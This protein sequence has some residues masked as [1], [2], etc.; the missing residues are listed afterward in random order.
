MRRPKQLPEQILAR[1]T[2]ILGVGISAGD[3]TSIVDPTPT[4]GTDGGVEAPVLTPSPSDFI[5]PSTPTLSGTVQGIRVS[6]DGKNANGNPYPAGAFVE[7]H[8]STSGATFTPSS[9]TLAGRLLGSAG[10]FTIGALTAGTTYY[11]RLVGVDEAGNTTS[12]STAASGQTGLTTENDYGTGTV[13]VGAVSFNARQ[14]GGIATTVGS[15]A[16][17]SPVT[18]DIWLDSSSGTSIIHK[19]WNGSSWVTQAWGSDSLSANCITSVQLATGAIVAGSAVI[20]DA[21]IRNAQIASI[22]ADK[23]TAGVIS[24]DRIDTNTLTGKTLRTAASGKRVE[25]SSSG[26][27]NG[28]IEFYNSSSVR[29]GYI[30]GGSSYVEIGAPDGAIIRG[31]MYGGRKVGTTGNP[32]ASLSWVGSVSLGL[33]PAINDALRISLAGAVFS[34]GIDEATTG[35]AANVRVG[36]SAQLLKSTSTVRIKDQLAPLT[37]DLTGVPD[38][39]IGSVPASVDPYDVLTI[40]PTEFRSLAAADGEA[41][42]LGFIAEDVATKLPWAANWDDDGQPSA[43]E[44]RPILAALLYVV[45]QQ[46]E[47]IADLTARLEALEA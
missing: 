39:K 6:W 19:R 26:S 35:S 32:D 28:Q 45:R 14:I 47:Q 21:A 15:T 7:I 33:S 1:K 38:G 13:G 23:I 30:E 29:K 41:R 16:P 17:T 18:G 36:A 5:A 9:S 10:F 20:G 12:P 25:V 24:A 44:D 34:Y 43:V 4:P 22:S 3:V 46:H 11:V 40:T 37:D 31:D 42:M 8:I 27:N 2:A